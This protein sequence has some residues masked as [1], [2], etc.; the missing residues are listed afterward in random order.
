MGGVARA[1]SIVKDVDDLASGATSRT[2]GQSTIK[3]NCKRKKRK[4]KKGEANNLTCFK[5]IDEW[6]IVY[7]ITSTGTKTF[8]QNGILRTFCNAEVILIA[9]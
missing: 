3:C 5:G 9:T 1:V 8:R 2:T 6:L 7:T 4:K